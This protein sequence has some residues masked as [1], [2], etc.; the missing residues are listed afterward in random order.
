VELV[1][2]FLLGGILVSLFAAV[3]SAVTPKTFAGLFGAAP[4]IALASLGWSYYSNGR[5]EVALLA[6]SM[7]LGSARLLAYSI[8][9]A[10]A[11]RRRRVWILPA[12]V[13][14][15]L[16]WFLSAGTLMKVTGLH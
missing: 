1:V 11:V 9:C 15:W 2:R 3:G 7:V 4:P 8:A 5:V 6:R 13:L 12:T 10:I 14:A 16:A